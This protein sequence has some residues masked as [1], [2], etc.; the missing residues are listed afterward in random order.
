MRRYDGGVSHCAV[1]QQHLQAFQGVQVPKPLAEDRGINSKAHA[2]GAQPAYAT[3][4]AIHA[5][6]SVHELSDSEAS[7]VA[8]AMMGQT[9]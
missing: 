3:Y 9:L 2:C 4:P 6:C 8:E 7:L 1:I 5:Y